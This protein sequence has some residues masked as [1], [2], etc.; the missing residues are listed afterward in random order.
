MKCIKVLKNIVRKIEKRH[1]FIN[2]IIP[3]HI[4]LKP[5]TIIMIRIITDF[6]I[7]YEF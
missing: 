6:N 5:A 7:D 4:I 1:I 3:R 2:V